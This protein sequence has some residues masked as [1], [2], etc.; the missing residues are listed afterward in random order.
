MLSPLLFIIFVNNLPVQVSEI[1]AVVYA[2][3]FK[4][5]IKKS[6][7]MQNDRKQIENRCFD[8]KIKANKNK[9]QFLPTKVKTKP[10]EA[11]TTTH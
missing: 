9:C 2:E 5:V 3:D 4:F 8:N 6:E 11:W 10:K 7:N 1:Y